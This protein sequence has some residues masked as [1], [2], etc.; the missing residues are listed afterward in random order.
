ML[1]KMFVPCTFLTFVLTSLAT[2]GPT[3]VIF[4]FLEDNCFQASAIPDGCVDLPLFSDSFST[5]SLAAP[6]VECLLSPERGCTSNTGL[7]AI[8]SNAAGTVELSTLGLPTVASFLCTPDA[9]LITLCFAVVATEGCFQ[10]ST[11]TGTGCTNLPRFSEPF[12]MASLTTAGTQCALSESA[13]CSGGASLFDPAPLVTLDLSSINLSNVGSFEC[14]KGTGTLIVP[15]KYIPPFGHR[16]LFRTALDRVLSRHRRWGHCSP[17][18]AEAG[19]RW[20]LRRSRRTGMENAGGLMSRVA[21]GGVGGDDDTEGGDDD[22]VVPKL[23]RVHGRERE[24]YQATHGNR[25]HNMVK[26]KVNLSKSPRP[27]FRYE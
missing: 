17:P 2:A 9:D 5:A 21:M 11:I 10:A 20:S 3:L 7:P 14:R 23:E 27:H 6:G 1:K 12:V 16:I 19:G 22:S 4:C 24:S 26:T 13:D 15:L 25:S 18:G 8:L